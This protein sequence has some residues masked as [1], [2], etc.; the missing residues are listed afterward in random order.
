MDLPDR[1][2]SGDLV[3]S[4]TGV[5]TTVVRTSQKDNEFGEP[6][7]RLRYNSGIVGHALYTRDMLCELGCELVT[8]E[9]E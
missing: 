5:V 6:L 2:K 8:G 4:P 9:K 1:L 3:R 7:Y